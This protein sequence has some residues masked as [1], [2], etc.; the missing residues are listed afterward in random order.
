MTKKANQFKYLIQDLKRWKADKPSQFFYFCFDLGVWATILYR[1]RRA[2]FLINIPIVRVFL[3]LIGF[4]LHKFS[5]VFL[6][7]CISSCTDIG[8]GLY[9]GHTG[10]IRIHPDAKA[11]KNLNIG[12]T[13]TIGVLGDGH[14]AGVPIIGDNVF[15]HTGAVVLGGIRIG[16]NVR[17]GANAVVLS[18]IPDNA[19]AVGVPA[20]VVKIRA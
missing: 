19:T 14:N 16:N 9:I 2:L 1:I 4:S 20:K 10:A 12:S 3:R 13:V 15:I 17:I 8:P 11:G 18:D 5:E 7:V 6:G